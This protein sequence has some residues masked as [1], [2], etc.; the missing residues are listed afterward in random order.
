MPTVYSSAPIDV[1]KS[2][3]DQRTVTGW[4]SVIEENG[5]PVVDFQGDVIDEGDLEKA[6]HNFVMDE[7]AGKL[8]HQ[9]KRVA[10]VVASFPMTKDIQKALGI[11]LKKV[12]WLITMKIRDEELWKRVKAGEFPAFSI[13]GHG[14]REA[15]P[16]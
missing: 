6:A 10:D 13:G 7:R 2:N 16:E 11:D 8:M 9:G 3:D 4:A 15:I 12:G 1:L 14:R 5:V